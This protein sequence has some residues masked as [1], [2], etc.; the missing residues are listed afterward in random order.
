[1]I[2]ILNFVENC[3]SYDARNDFKIWL[4]TG[5]NPVDIKW[6][7]GH[8]GKCNIHFKIKDDKQNCPMRSLNITS[9]KRINE[10]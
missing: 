4:S 2:Y 1:M 3:L 8:F 6:F 5:S 9:L 10:N 7:Q